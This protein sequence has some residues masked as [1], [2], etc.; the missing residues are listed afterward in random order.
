MKGLL[1]H[2]GNYWKVY[3]FLLGLT[4]FVYLLGYALNGGQHSS[5][6]AWAMVVDGSLM[7]MIILLQQGRGGGLVG[8]LGGMGGQSAFGTRAGDAF[9]GITIVLAVMW[10]M[11][12]GFGGIALRADRDSRQ[13]S[14]PEVRVVRSI[15]RREGD[16]EEDSYVTVP[17]HLSRAVEKEVTVEFK[18]GAAGDSAN[19]GDDY[20]VDGQLGENITIVESELKG[21]TAKDGGPAKPKTVEDLGRGVHPDGTSDYDVFRHTFEITFLPGETRKTI[22]IRVLGDDEPGSTAS[23]QL[24]VAISDARN[25]VLT[26]SSRSTV[27]I[28][29]DD[30]EIARAVDP[31]APTLKRAPGDSTSETGKKP[32]EKK[33]AEKKSAEKK[34]VEKKSAEKKPAEKKPAEKK[35]A[36]KK[37]AKKKSAKKKPAE[38]KQ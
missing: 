18:I 28:I 14:D 22:Q 27:S 17:M 10:V 37:S 23:R 5:G 7:I 13:F 35:S 2:L 4:A 33:P 34:P 29:D 21:T 32:A 6:L 15:E 8:A 31:Q 30:G 38:K 11:L 24:T 12:A 16:G 19:R 36:K 20:Q 26:K 9:T 25:A 3:T 1:E